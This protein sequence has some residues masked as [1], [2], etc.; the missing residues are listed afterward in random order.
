[1]VSVVIA[2]LSLLTKAARER[3]AQDRCT[4]YYAV[5]GDAPAQERGASL[6]WVEEGA[7]PGVL[8]PEAPCERAQAAALAWPNWEPR[9]NRS[10]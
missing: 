3:Y 7:G 6:K 5:H 10:G 2:A 9:V 1:M 4:N 8:K